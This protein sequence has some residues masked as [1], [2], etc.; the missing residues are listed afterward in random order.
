[1]SRFV[2][3]SGGLWLVTVALPFCFTTLPARA[4]ETR[5]SI[6]GRVVDTTNAAVPNATVKATNTATNVTIE[7]R[8][9]SEGNYI[10]P[11]LIPG[12]YDLAASANGFKMTARKD[13]E[14][15]IHET[16]QLDF[17]LEVGLVTER[18]EV[19]SQ[20]P[21]IETGSASIGQVID[22]RRIQELPI[23]Y[24]SPYTLMYLLPGLSNAYPTGM[25]DQEPTNLNATTTRMNVNGSPFGTTEFTIDGVPN[26]QTSNA[27]YGVGMSNSPP[28]DMVQ[29]FKLETAFDASVGHT[30]GTIVNLV[31]KS[32]TNQPHGTAYVF[33][34]D[35][36]WAANTFFGNYFGQPRGDFTYKLWG[37]SL[38]GPIYIPKVYNGKS[39]T[40]FSYGYEGM[41]L[42]SIFQGTTLTVPDPKN[43][44]GDF[45][46]LL[47][48]GTQYQ[49]YDPSTIQ[50]TGNGR[51]SIQPFPGNIVPANRI[52]PVA[53]SLLKHYP[54][55][56]VT[57]LA[58]GTNN[59]ADQTTA[60]P[61]LYYNHLAR[62]DHTISDRQRLSGRVSVSRK[63][64]G[65]Y[66]A[67]WNDAAV[68]NIYL[69]KTRQFSLDDVYTFSPSFFMDVRY[70]YTRYAGGHFPLRLGYDVSQLGFPSA[71]TSLLT[72]TA[73]IFPR[74][75]ISG[76]QGLGSESADVLN[77]DVH[78]FFVSFS[79]QHGS[80]NLKFGADLRAYRDN[81]RTYGN[82]TGYFTFGTAYTQGP[83]D[84]SPSSPS[85][86]GQGLAALLLGQPT[87]GTIDRNG[88]QAIESTY[89][90]FYLHDNWRAT[91]KLTLDLGLRWEYEGP[92]TERFNRSV[93]GFDPNAAQPIAAKALANYAANPDPS[94]PVSQFQVKGGLLFAGQNGVSR[95]LW[96]RSLRNFAPRIGFAYHLSER[97]ALRGGFGL[98]PIQI[99]Q[100]AQN[101]AI[102]TG[103]SQAT[104]LVPTLDNGL[105]F[106]ANLSNPFPN[107]ILSPPG[108]SLGA[109]TYLG[110][111]INIYNP[112]PRTP[113]EMHWDFNT[114]T[115]LPGRVLLE[116]GYFGSKAVKLEVS[117]N[118]D[119]IPDKYL[120]TS[121][122][123]DQATINYLTANV[124]NPFAGLLP[125]TSLNGTTIS[126]TQLLTPYPQFTS[127]T[128]LDYQ[129][130]SW[131]HSVQVRME[132]RFS[133]GFT[134]LVGYT[135]SKTMEA[136]FY[137]NGG[138]PTPYREISAMD[139]P[140]H[141]SFS[142]IFELPF[143]KGKPVLPNVGRIA[144][145]IVGDW[146]LDPV[147]QLSSGQPIGFGNALFVGNIKDIALP[148]D[149]RTPQ[150]WF[151]TSGFVTASSQQLANNLI[152][153][154]TLFSGIRSGIYNS[155]D[156]SALKNIQIHEK[157]RFQ[158]RGEFLN[159]FNHP[160]GFA[161]PNTSPT[162]SAFGQVTTQY[163]WPRTIQLGLKY[164]F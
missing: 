114:Q 154:P 85:G 6:Q 87:T 126:R 128:M 68:G 95:M 108:A 162:S 20:L 113:Y 149:Q 94:L 164:L 137:L 119:A 45:S 98:Y 123:R 140:Q 29:E 134:A 79:K 77:N 151:N 155:W 160:T 12:N 147:W 153:F 16:L 90:A 106:T 161:P 28:A 116:I 139:R 152:T 146:Q 102:L 48:L 118:M 14:L 156:I 32:G 31:L 84:N 64:D 78:S 44:G 110:L 60:E 129:G 5:G 115:L 38:S 143:G 37:A 122:T 100:P 97:V 33:L 89:W 47:K 107:G 121:P 83:L 74:I 88:S 73:Q 4:Q 56:N 133:K 80:H 65:P 54:A 35:P 13:I 19:A 8:S 25:L 22:V 131:Y 69:G 104:S 150:R 61:L 52:S 67:Y 91:R 11:L 109:Q 136:S 111:G 159:V 46:N 36:S 21:L 135:F 15:R 145:A 112:A 132:R 144:N 96:D 117:R 82:A 62:L 23:S 105:D 158:F 148:S 99:G 130:Y 43:F 10:L 49:I 70:G 127:F 7:T 101:R 75:A 2:S 157:H 92:V 124:P 66:R 51:F 17:G 30:S 103:F 142:G 125:G 59:F 71:A 57:G 18:V 1:M 24:G 72:Q 58:D 27:D 93:R 141:L 53:L 40:F 86:I 76:E 55:P 63:I 42:N 34:R 138:D 26:T 163:G 9:N 39:R 3:K 120:S 81:D 50:A 41:H